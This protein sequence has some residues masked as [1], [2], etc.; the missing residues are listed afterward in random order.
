[1]KLNPADAGLPSKLGGQVGQGLGWS[2]INTI[3]TRLTNVVVGVILARILVPEDYGVFAVAIVVLN[4]ALSMNELGVSLAVIRWPG[5]PHRI[6]PTVTTMALTWSLLLYAICFAMAPAVASMMGSPE[7][8]ALV[9]V[10]GLAIL[11]DAAAAVPSALL[12]RSFRQRARLAIDAVCIVVGALISVLLALTAH[13]AWS[14]AWGALVSSV[15]S[16][17]LTLW[18][19]PVRYRPGLDREVVRELLTFGLPLAGASALLFLSINVDN[20]VVGHVLGPEALGF[21]A[22]AFNVCSWPVNLVSVAVRRV[23][24]A[25]FS[26]LIDQEADPGPTIA[27]SFALLMAVTIPGCALLG[28]YSRQVIATVYGDTWLPAAEALTLLCVLAAIRI[29]LELGYD[30]LA[31][32]GHSSTNLV[33]QGVWLLALVPALSVGAANDGIRGVALAHAVLAGAL[34]LPLFLFM[35]AKRGLPVTLLARLCVRPLLAGGLVIISGLVVRS[36]VTNPTASLLVG[37]PVSA[38]LAVAV[39]HPMRRLWQH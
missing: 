21:Y 30:Y 26:R 31:A 32:R 9:R 34:V 11:I 28:V 25:G 37:G 1:M 12:T 20:V 36:L 17:L 4:G 15:L 14:L 7:S 29:L 3:A 19:T 38:V 22:L 27:K 8:T 5:S 16:G 6:A 35:A 33:L 23:S 39:I 24:F 10:L 13:G 2:A 18:A